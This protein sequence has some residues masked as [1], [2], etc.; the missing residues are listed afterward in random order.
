MGFTGISTH[1]VPTNVVTCE[2]GRNYGQQH[3]QLAKRWFSFSQVCQ[4]G[5][6]VSV[7]KGQNIFPSRH[8]LHYMGFTQSGWVRSLIKHQPTWINATFHFHLLS[9]SQLL[10]LPKTSYGYDINLLPSLPV[11]RDKMPHTNH[12]HCTN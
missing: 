3:V 7:T 12:L 2:C 5:I 9:C 8:I 4:H 11:H 6:Y 1:S 10:D